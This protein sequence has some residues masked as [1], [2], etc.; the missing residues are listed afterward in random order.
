MYFCIKNYIGAQ[1]KLVDSTC[2]LNTAVV[3]ATDRSKAVVLFL[4][5]CVFVVFSTTGRFML[6]FVLL[7]VLVFFFFQS[8]LAL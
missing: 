1:G 2:A 3:Y 5:L 4:F 7:F 8:C 6:S